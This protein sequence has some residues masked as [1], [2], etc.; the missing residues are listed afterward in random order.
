M[1]LAFSTVMP[2]AVAGWTMCSLENRSPFMRAW[3][4]GGLR[5]VTGS[6][7]EELGPVRPRR[8][9]AREADPDVG[10]AGGE[11][12]GAVARAV[13]PALDDL[14]GGALTAGYVLAD[15][16]PRGSRGGGPVPGPAPVGRGVGV[17]GTGDHVGAVS[18]GGG[19]ETGVDGQ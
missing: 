10:E 3:C 11:D 14:G 6:G 17:E 1:H 7:A 13:H 16:A 2:G 15:R 18:L 9:T 4:P 19:G 12:V 5:S 8:T